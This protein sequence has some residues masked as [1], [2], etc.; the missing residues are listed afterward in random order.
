MDTSARPS[1]KQ[2]TNLHLSKK[3]RIDEVI[4]VEVATDR[5]GEEEKSTKNKEETNERP[6]FFLQS[7]SS[8]LFKNTTQHRITKKYFL[9]EKRQHGGTSTTCFDFVFVC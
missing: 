4:D 7:H 9:L 6:T 8:A 1:L 2:I 5:P 3:H